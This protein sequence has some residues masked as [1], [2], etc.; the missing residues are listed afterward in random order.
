[1]SLDQTEL[2]RRLD[3]LD[4]SRG[5]SRDELRERLPGLPE[6]VYLYLPAAKKYY[7][8]HEVL[9]NVGAHALARA[10][11][12]DAGPELDLPVDGAEDDGGPAAYGPSVSPG[13]ETAEGSGD[14]AGP[15]DDIAGNSLETS[16]GRG[17]PDDYD[18]SPKP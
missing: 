9:N 2:H 13:G 16:A 8:A 14:Y 17:I 12:E 1:M 15:Y 3:A 6:E 7:S 11:G 18:D 5:L 10:E 4:M